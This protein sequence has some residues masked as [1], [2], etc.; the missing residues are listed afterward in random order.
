MSWWVLVFRSRVHESAGT[1]LSSFHASRA[2]SPSRVPKA[3]I[4]C[5]KH[6]PLALLYSVRGMF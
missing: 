2:V 6:G 5:L 3:E 4:F 1:S